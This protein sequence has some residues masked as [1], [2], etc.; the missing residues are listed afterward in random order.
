MFRT[1]KPS[2]MLLGYATISSKRTNSEIAPHRSLLPIR[3]MRKPAFRLA[4][5][6]RS[7]PLVLVGIIVKIPP[8]C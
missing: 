2:Q 3:D 6:T 5:L 8:S 7:G 4:S 1:N